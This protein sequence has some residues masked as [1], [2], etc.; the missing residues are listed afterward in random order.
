M[1]GSKDAIWSWNEIFFCA[2]KLQVEKKNPE[3]WTHL[4]SPAAPT[5][6]TFSKGCA[7]LCLPLPRR[8]ELGHWQQAV[9]QSP[10]VSSD[11]CVFS[12]SDSAADHLVHTPL[13]TW[14]GLSG[15]HKHAP[16]C[17][18][19]AER[20]FLL[21]SLRTAFPRRDWAPPSFPRPDW[22]PGARRPAG[23]RRK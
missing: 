20:H 21:I 18:P 8:Q 17:T 2:S 9:S 6:H 14:L 1:H 12:V 23:T 3:N 22:F 7:G 19:C 4:L 13:I 15:G 16:P 11:C 10:S 5:Q